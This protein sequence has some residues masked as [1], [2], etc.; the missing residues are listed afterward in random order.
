MKKFMSITLIALFI[1]NLV[2]SQIS[3]SETGT[4]PHA[5]AMLDISSSNKGLLVPRIT[6][7]QTTSPSPVSSPA[8]G[9]LI[10]NTATQNDVT[11]GYYYW[12]ANQSKWIRLASGNV[13]TGTG[14]T[15]YN[16]YWTSPTT[17]GAEQ[18]VAIS[19]GGTGI[20][21]TPANGQLLIGNGSGYTLNTLTAGSGITITNGSGT[22]TI[23]ATGGTGTAWL[24]TGNAGTTPGTNFLGTTDAKDLLFKVN[25]KDAYAI[26]YDDTKEKRH[27][28]YGFNVN[29]SATVL[30]DFEYRT[31]S[32]PRVYIS[33]YNNYAWGPNLC[34]GP[35]LVLSRAKGT[36]NA[37]QTVDPGM[38]L[39][40][41]MITSGT[42]TYSWPEMYHAAIVSQK[43]GTASGDRAADLRFYTVNAS[44]GGGFFDYERMRIGPSGGIG[45]NLNTGNPN[46]NNDPHAYVHVYGGIGIGPGTSIS[47]AINV[48][49]GVRNSIQISTETDYGGTYNDHS[50]YLI[51]SIM[52]G[53]WGTA[54][55]RFAC[56]DNWGS[57]NTT[58]PALRITQTAGY[59]NGNLISTSDKRLKTNI[60]DA[61][62]GLAEV[63]KL[64][65][66]SYTRH[67]ADTIIN[68]VPRYS[69]LEGHTWNEIGFIAQEVY[70]IIPEVVSKPKD[71]NKDFWGIDYGKLVPILT[72]AI[73]EQ[74][75]QIEQLKQIIEEQ[76]KRIKNL[77]TK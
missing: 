36:S 19:R 14:T 16:A 33:Q 34:D 64:K 37:P 12:D 43:R 69:Q 77:E 56:S 28:F 26:K 40:G 20:G 13:I 17:I 61:Q 72:K 48:V 59:I 29:S 39:G 55:L 10:F 76:N 50:G 27:F 53:G 23:S 41:I 7:T 30:T 3:I 60:K 44:D 66:R 75:A 57:Y 52:P 68:G 1:Y 18:Y 42:L 38:W 46:P 63:L 25:N 2:Y 45:I 67:I 22:I 58:T 8:N 71:E 6:L 62:Y 31:E 74:Q 54:E 51:Y 47:N 73:Q 21:T 35:L 11:P 70:E 32:S 65:P 49:H 24:L 5:S 4:D 9:L 15:N